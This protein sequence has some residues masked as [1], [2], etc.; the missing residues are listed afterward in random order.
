MVGAIVLALALVTLATAATGAPAGTAAAPTPTVTELTGGLTPGFSSLSDPDGI[1]TG[2]DGHVWFT[3]YSGPGGSSAQSAGPGGVGRVNDDGTV[4]ELVG[5]KTPGF[6]PKGGP[7]AI[8][9]GPNG[10]V[11]FTE[12]LDPGRLAIVVEGK[13]SESTA[14]VRPGF[15]ANRAPGSVPDG[16]AVGPGGT[17]WFTEYNDPGGLGEVVNGTV[18][19][20]HGRG[21]AGIQRQPRPRLRHSRDPT[22]T[23]GSP[24]RTVPAG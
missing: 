23:S 5:G 8:T 14:G 22:A 18:A 6:D 19:R 9:T 20:A 24:S 4:T 13:V 3:E 10:R 15:T 11:W 17:V 21:D 1:T 16:L 2:P 7:E 12:Y